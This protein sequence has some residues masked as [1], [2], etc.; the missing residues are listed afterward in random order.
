MLGGYNLK[1]LRVDLTNRNITTEEIDEMVCR[2]Y[3]GGAGFTTYFLQKELP[4]GADALGPENKLIFATGPATGVPLSGSGRHCVGAKSPLTGGIAKSEAGGFWGT[5]LKR[6][7]YDAIIVEGKASKPVYLWVSEDQVSIRDAS[8]MWGKNTKETQQAIISELGDR[9]I[10]V[11]LI[12]PAAEKLVSYAC[13]MHG[14][15]CAAGRGGTGAVMGSKNLKAIA[16]RGHKKIGVA[17]PE[18]LGVLRDWLAANMAMVKGFRE[19]GTGGGMEAFEAMGNLPVHNW[20]GG[21]FPHA[22]KISAVTIKKTI[23]V[24]MET[25][26]GCAVRCKKKVKVDG[27]YHVDPDYGGPEYEALAAFGSNCNIDDLEALCKANELCNA[28]SLDVISTGGSIAFAMECFEKGLL[29]LKDTSGLDLSFGNAEAMLDLVEMIARREGIGELL[30]KGT[31]AAAKEIGGDALAFAMHVKGLEP[32]MHEPRIKT[33]FALGYMVN[34]HGADHNCN[35]HDDFDTI[36]QKNKIKSMGI[37]E[38]LAP[39]NISPGKVALFKIIHSKKIMCDSLAICTFLPYN[40][41]QLAS[42]TQAVTGWETTVAEQLRVADRILTT[43]RLVNV[44]EGLSALDDSLPQRYYEPRT[45]G[46]HST[47]VLDPQRMEKAKRYYYSLMGW[48][49]EGVPTPEKLEELGIA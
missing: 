44:R 6:A 5:A 1:L 43:A 23:S 42:I 18:G 21:S 11:A 49:A 37:V 16:V 39:D 47:K 31:M 12:G 25:C 24:G 9:S 17:N 35:I 7:G 41:S 4:V 26:F 10:R 13:I 20:R 14:L 30:G 3:I 2:K 8:R 36:D 40:N 27:R 34:P 45:D 29:T 22:N 28:Y 15:Y 33:G 46:A 32:G 38:P 48:T 19:Y